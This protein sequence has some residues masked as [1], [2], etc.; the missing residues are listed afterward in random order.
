MNWEAIGAVSEGLGAL[1]V[2]VTLAYLAIQIRHQNASNGV[3]L[4]NSVLDGYNSVNSLVAA[5]RTVAALFNK[6]L[7][8]PDQL[9]D[10]EATQFAMLMRMWI[11]MIL[12]LYQLHRAGILS[13][14]DWDN[15][16]KQMATLFANPGGQQFLAGQQ[17]A[18]KDFF[19]TLRRIEPDPLSV[20]LTLGRQKARGM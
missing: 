6:G 14:Y 19:D 7:T 17:T 1:A 3:A 5:D 20:D 10:E 15:H 18:F 2:F 4:K 13:D 9:T 8:D 16:S 12:K 11:N